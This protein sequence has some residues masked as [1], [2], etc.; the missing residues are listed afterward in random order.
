LGCIFGSYVF[1]SKG[2]EYPFH[3]NCRDIV[4]HLKASKE[5]KDQKI[6][7]AAQYIVDRLTLKATN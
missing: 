3:E 6:V 5:D 4:E 1:M 2:F 7:Q